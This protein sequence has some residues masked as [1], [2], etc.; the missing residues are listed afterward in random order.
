MIEKDSKKSQNVAIYKYKCDKCDYYTCN[1][2]DYNKHLETDKHKMI[3]KDSKKSQNVATDGFTCD[4][5][6]TYKHHSN[7]CRHKKNCMSKC[8]LNMSS[9]SDII[10]HEMSNET[11]Y[12]EIIFQLIK[13]NKEMH[14][15]IFE[16]AK[17]YQQQINEL[18][19]K[20]GNNI[21]NTINNNQKFNINIFLN[22]NCKDAINIHDFVDGIEISTDDLLV[23]KDKGLIG[24]ISNIVINELNKLPLIQRPLWCSDKKRKRLFIKQ[25]KWTE[26]INN[27][28]TKEV[29][30]N[31]SKKQTKNITKYSKEN[32][33]WMENDNLKDNYMLII[34]NATDPIEDKTDKIIDNLINL[35]HMDDNKNKII[36]EEK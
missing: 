20:I 10:D 27:T 5:G 6:K 12:K 7:L 8:Q 16:Q 36:N 23:T 2:F 24:G 30:K 32:P 15:M 25:E 17:Q 19:P 13:Q 28:I 22:E 18:I 1:K 29:I 26:D 9:T 14:E 11:N 31:V 3:L 33:N 4:C 35:I 34:K 21:N